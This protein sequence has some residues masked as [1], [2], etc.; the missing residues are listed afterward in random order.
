MD[1]ELT[2]K[3]L[4]HPKSIRVWQGFRSAVL[5]AD[6]QRFSEQLGKIFIPA[7][8]QQMQP[9][10]LQAYFPLILSDSGFALP[11][12]LAL[13]VY[14]TQ[15]AYTVATKE[16]VAGRAYGA[17]HSTVFNFNRDG[18]IPRS[19]SYFPTAW[20]GSFE[21]NKPVYLIDREINWHSGVMRCLVIKS[22][23][24]AGII[25]QYERIAAIVNNWLDSAS[26]DV[27]NVIIQAEAGYLMCWEH[28]VQASEEG[29]TGALMTQV[30]GVVVINTW[31]EKVLVKPL[32]S[33]ADTGV[34]PTAG[35]LMDV[36]LDVEN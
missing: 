15:E 16:T 35:L 8:V 19:R 34:E 5:A 25:Q 11:D 6:W 4:A 2:R 32:F 33:V 14:P 17:L 3:G 29:V 7:T 30:Q 12:E 13:V 31:A 9:L 22:R 27:D 26:G 20:S 36:R 10:S 21:D 24:S 28:Y 23:E 1:K 18:P